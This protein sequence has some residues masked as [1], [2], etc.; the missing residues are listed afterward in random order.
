MLAADRASWQNPKILS[1]LLLVF[2]AGALTGALFMR[3]GLHDRLHRSSSGP[4]SNP[5][6]AEIFL[7][8]CE[9][10]LKLSPQ[11]AEQMKAVLD[12]YKLYYQSLQ[13]SLEEVR[14]TGKT[15]IMALLNDDQK[16]QVEKLL[17]EMK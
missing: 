6:S 15:R 14:A 13:V 2:V 4:L 8:R 1:T 12:D 17:V 5:K 11:Q 10:E 9:K 7:G 3:L 16:S